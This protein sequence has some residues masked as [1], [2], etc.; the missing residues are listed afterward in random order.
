M[1]CKLLALPDFD[2]KAPSQ[3]WY[4][5]NITTEMF[6]VLR[7]ENVR[8]GDAALVHARAGK[9]RKSNHIANCIDMRNIRPVLRIDE[10]LLSCAEIDVHVVAAQLFRIPASANKNIWTESISPLFN[11]RNT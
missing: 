7:L 4:A 8:N 2:A 1:G 5:M 3:I 10:H 6:E 11:K 9:G